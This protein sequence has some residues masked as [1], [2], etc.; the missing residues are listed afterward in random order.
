MMYTSVSRCLI[1][2]TNRYKTSPSRITADLIT[3]DRR[4]MEFGSI[5]HFII[6]QFAPIP[7]RYGTLQ[8]AGKQRYEALEFFCASCR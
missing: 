4:G 3:S 7:L 5:S 6:S 8:D 1:V 2:D